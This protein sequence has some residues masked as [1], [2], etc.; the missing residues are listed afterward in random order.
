MNE[1]KVESA[2]KKNWWRKLVS[3][4]LRI[5]LVVA[6]LVGLFMASS[7]LLAR[8]PV[9][10]GYQHAMDDG[11][12]ILLLNN[13]V[14][15]DLVIPIDEPSFRMREL[16]DGGTY[17]TDP[18]MYT[19]AIF[20]WGNRKFYLETQSWDDL[21]L[22]NVLYAFTGLGE[23]AVHVELTTGFLFNMKRERQ[24]LLRLSQSQFGSAKG[25]NKVECVLDFGLLHQI[26]FLHA[27]PKMLLQSRNPSKFIA[28]EDIVRLPDLMS[29]RSNHC[30]ASPRLFWLG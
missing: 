14:H 17:K 25:S 3:R 16:I 26:H 2:S 23:T 24:R 20:G 29:F 22:T 18:Q 1:T 10:R 21:K 19:H 8:I 15:V 13:G 6:L 11:V 5:F 7:Y 27:Y 28:I 4:G 30:V 12:E 9:N